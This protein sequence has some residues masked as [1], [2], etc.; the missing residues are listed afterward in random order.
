MIATDYQLITNAEELRSTVEKLKQH[1]VVGF[2][3][4]TTSLDPYRGDLRLVQLAVPGSV[5]IIDLKHFGDKDSWKKSD[6][7]APLRELLASARPIKIAH[8][9]KF[10]AKWAKHALGVEL[11]GLFD[12]LLAS[13]IVSAGDTD[14]RHN[15]EAVAARYLNETVDK[16]EQLSDWSGEL[17]ATQLEYAARDAAV[18]PPLREKQIEKL[19]ADALLRCA[20]LEFECVLPVAS[21]ELAGIYLDKE[22]WREQLA[23]VEKKRA[24]LAEQLQEMLAEESMQ[25]SLFG[26]PTRLDLNID[27]H[28]QLTKA[29]KRRG[30]EVPDGT[31]NWKLQ[32]L[33]EKHI[34]IKTLLE[35]RTVQKALTSYG[36]NILNEINP[37][38]GRIHADFRQIGA[39]TGRFSCNNPN[40]QQV[41]HAIEY[42]RCFRAPEGRKF[43]ISDYCVA[44]GTRVATRRG[45]VK[46]EQVEIGDE[47]FL[48]N[49]STANVSAVIARG[50]LPVSTVT[51]KNGYSLTATSLHRIRVLNA[52]GDYVWRRIQDL[53]PGDRVA[54]QPAR[55]LHEEL[56]DVILPEPVN[57]HFN[58]NKNLIAPSIADERLAAFMGYI[59]GDGTFMHNY[60]GWVVNL[61]D[62][63]VASRLKA[64]AAEMFG[65]EVHER[66]SYRGVAEFGLYSVPLVKWYSEIGISKSSLPEFLWRCRPSVVAAYLRGLFE[67]DGSIMDS[68]TGKASFSS[69]RERLAR[70]VHQMLLALGI[71]ATLREQKG[72]GPG[73]KFRCWS[74]SVVA[75]GLVQFYEQ[76]GFIS[77]RKQ[78]KLA[79]LVMRWTGKT[80]VGNMPNLGTKVRALHLSGEIRRQLNNISSLGR[81]LTASLASIIEANYPEVGKE[82]GLHHLTEYK[83]MFLS[84]VS[85][86]VSGELPVFDLSVP[87]PMTYI[88][89]GFVSHNSQIELRI[90]ADFT[91]DQG[92]VDAFNSGADLHKVTAAQVFNTPLEKVTKEQRD[93][94]KRLN[95]GVV[96]GIGAQRFAMM[97]GLSVTDAEDILRRYFSTYRQL[98]A[99]L[100]DAAQRAVRERTARTA[101]G[102]LA[103]FRFDS[104]DRQAVSLAQRNGKNTPIQGCQIFDS[105]ILT[106]EHGYTKIGT[107]SGLS[108]LHVW[109]GSRFVRSDVRPSGK[110][111]RVKVE[112]WGGYYNECS[113]DHKFFTIDVNG[114]TSWR[115]PAQFVKGNYVVLTNTLPEWSVPLELPVANHIQ[116][117]TAKKGGLENITERF[118]LGVWLGRIAS[119]GNVS[120]AQIRLLIAEHEK[121]ILP[122][123][124]RLS[125]SFGHVQQ[126][127]THGGKGIL[128]I[129]LLNLTFARLAYQLVEIGIKSRVPDC[130]WKDSRILA[131]YLRGM[132]DGDGT[133][134]KDGA[135][136]CFGKGPDFYLE[137]SREI[138]QALLLFGIR[139]RINRCADRINVCVLKRDMPLFCEQI[140]FINPQK[141]E[142][143]LAIKD[144]TGHENKIYGRAVRIKSVEFTDER[145]D[146]YDVVDSETS[147]FMVNGLVTHNSSADILKRALRLLHDEL[148]DTSACIVNIVHDEIV[149]EAD[150]NET[151]SIAKKV[152]DAMC[153]AGAEYVKKVPVKVETEIADEW[154][155]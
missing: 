92:F 4:E 54:V 27:S 39:P 147:Q 140:G 61:Q 7:L 43:I 88:S 100:R 66:G 129:Y 132:F 63:D 128:P 46:I 13:Q 106:K 139:S 123:L 124:L 130:A 50:I 99:W 40:V 59:A 11:G 152:E 32:P 146:M 81:P 136:L 23:V 141:Q 117:P 115:T 29:L 51:L 95:F 65:I 2:D 112:F 149:V 108:N 125:N 42:R 76:V 113:P 70:D 127:V 144:G 83:Q 34:E 71:P 121:Q 16:A 49:G 91:G 114:R 38:T 31:R 101:S 116:S 122:Y 48:E 94:A 111:Q 120:G 98:D 8:N 133:V 73:K 21:L 93:F 109:D 155:K 10:D 143:A 52:E 137:W 77:A 44:Q 118:D 64:W 22:R 24:L 104:E 56:P 134:N 151:E 150:M 3:T 17:S 67:S 87:G 35:Y 85:V 14:E 53:A 102:R 142:K 72:T 153:K 119:D 30:I 28:V 138:Q 145:V 12:T 37:V 1:A 86:V 107:L 135:I 69:S 58:N 68:E 82:L 41:P 154:V 6:A 103:R 60:I 18:L 90:L 75:S 110:K 36:E 105:R 62:A 84:V 5:H 45:L 20:Q 131:G 126:K 96:Y 9:A 55:G 79:A 148:R 15:L 57:T 78:A 80:V 26:G 97:T 74:V 19:K 33:A 89:D 47:V 25:G